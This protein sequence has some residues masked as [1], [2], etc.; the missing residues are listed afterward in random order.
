MEK[1]LLL[2]QQKEIFIFK[3]TQTDLKKHNGKKVEIVRELQEKEADL[4]E[5]GKMYVIKLVGTDE[6]FQAFEDELEKT[7]EKHMLEMTIKEEI[8]ENLGTTEQI[9][10]VYDITDYR[11]QV[12]ITYDD[13]ERDDFIEVEGFQTLIC[14]DEFAVSS[15]EITE[16]IPVYVEDYV[17]D[18]YANMVTLIQD[19]QHPCSLIS[20]VV[21]G[22]VVYGVEDDGKI[23]EYT[24]YQEAL[25][26]YIKVA[27]LKNKT[28][29]LNS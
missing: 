18:Y 9:L 20:I 2:N 24:N 21:E 17:E 3:T 25:E 15:R 5:V 1:E 29:N 10:Y 12:G 8:L 13:W 4:G 27:Y 28:Y 16:L 11:L 6:T 22:Q 26:E 19:S 23:E 14:M 7:I